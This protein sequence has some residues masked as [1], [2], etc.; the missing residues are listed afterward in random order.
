MI[1]AIAMMIE[2][3]AEEGGG[4][5][6]PPDATLIITESGDTITTESGDKLKTEDSP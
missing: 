1:I 2:T 4:S 6:A 5:P 3:S